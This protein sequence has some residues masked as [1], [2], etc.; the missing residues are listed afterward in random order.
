MSAEEEPD[1]DALLGRIAQKDRQAFQELMKR[2]GRTMIALA[3]RMTGNANDADD[4]VQDAFLKV[5]LSAPSWRRGEAMF[6][7]WLYRVVLN[8][9]IDRHRQRSLS[10]LDEMNE[11]NG[12]A[13]HCVSEGLDQVLIHQRHAMIVRAMS[14]LPEKQR[15][16]LSLYYFA[17]TT[18][19]QATKILLLSTSAFESLLFRGKRAL[20]KILHRHGITDSGDIL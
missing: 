12:D 2:H 6:S 14:D 9:C 16:A 20:M 13:G 7:T 1:D 19:P 17:E 4:I 3:Q 15:T 5:W 10:S 18:A 11:E 8:L